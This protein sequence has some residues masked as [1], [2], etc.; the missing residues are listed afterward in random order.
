MWSLRRLFFLGVVQLLVRYIRQ[1]H[2]LDLFLLVSVPLLMLPSILSLAFPDENPS[3]NRTGGAIIPVFLI[4]ALA[5]EGLLTG[6]Y[7]RAN[8]R[9]GIGFYHSARPGSGWRIDGSELRSGI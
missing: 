1:R 5:L 8:T 3:L 2:W 7:R 6:L 9:W 4:A